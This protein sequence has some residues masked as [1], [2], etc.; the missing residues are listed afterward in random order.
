MEPHLSLKRALY[1]L[2][3]V[4]GFGRRGYFIPYRYASQIGQTHQPY[5]WI[6]ERFAACADGTF[7]EILEEIAT[8]RTALEKIGGDPPEPRWAQDW[9]PGLDGA[10]LYAMVRKTKPSRILEIGSG[11]S[12][13]FVMRAIRDGGVSAEVTCVDPAPRA[14]LAGL[15]LTLRREP[16]QNVDPTSLPALQAGDMLIVDSSHIAM[17]GSDV[18]WVVNRFL[19]RL[20]AGV[21]VHFHDIFLPDPYPESW[22]WRGYN[23]QVVVAA[24]IAGGRASP[25]FASH[26]IRRRRPD[27]IDSMALGWIPLIDGAIES[28]LW[29]VLE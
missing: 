19:P 28:S 5:A 8:H 18:D 20:P 7:S 26:F 14:D 13:R 11:H 9:F 10:A 17:P 4:L 22:E 12:T 21:L 27:L 25:V 24:L 1:G 23:E 6:S 3:T 15:D 16:V 2:S 29:M